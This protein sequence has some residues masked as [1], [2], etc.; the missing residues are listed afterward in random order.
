MTLTMAEQ[1]GVPVPMGLGMGKLAA[2]QPEAAC[3]AGAYCR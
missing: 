3:W 1:G 2:P